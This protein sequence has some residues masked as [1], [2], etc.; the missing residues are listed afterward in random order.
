MR[1]SECGM[2]NSQ[3]AIRNPSAACGRYNV[4]MDE[5]RPITEGPESE[6][7]PEAPARPA[8][9]VG[10]LPPLPARPRP[11]R[12][13]GAS[14]GRWATFGCVA[15]LL[16]LVVLLMVGVNLTRRTV[17]MSYARAQQ[18][19]VEELPRDLPSGERLRTERN[20]QRYRARLEASPDPLPAIGGLLAE[21]AR[22][23]DDDV[24]TADEVDGLN[25]FLEQALAADGEPPR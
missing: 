17:W 3:F 6:P 2:R 21:A 25:R 12:V 8:V 14:I 19:L 9:D 11:D 13:P 4:G 23:L 7:R 20:L 22:V 5:E 10:M 15:V 16:M 24:L 1:N 18:R